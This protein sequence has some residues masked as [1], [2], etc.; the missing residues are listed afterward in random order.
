MMLMLM[1][2]LIMIINKIVRKYGALI[3]VCVIVFVHVILLVYSAAIHSPTIREK[4]FAPS[5]IFAQFL[6]GAQHE[7]TFP[8][9]LK[10]KT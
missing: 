4:H 1:L 5:C 9:L 6:L 8:H 10:G 3:T 7:F 2:M